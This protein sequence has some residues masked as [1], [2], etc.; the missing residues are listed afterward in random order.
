MRKFHK[1]PLRIVYV[2]V[3]PLLW[4]LNPLRLRAHAII[5]HNDEVLVVQ[6]RIGWG[7]WWLPGGGVGHGEEPETAAVR[8]ILE[9][10]SLEVTSVRR[11]HSDIII[12]R[13]HGITVRGVYVLAR[14]DQ[15]PDSITCLLYT[16]PSPRDRTRSRMPSSA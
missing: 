12:E 7:D 6:E 15:K 11:L 1:K 5:A 2:L 16:S 8:E 14:L 10:L 13:R 4:L 9:E 3:Y